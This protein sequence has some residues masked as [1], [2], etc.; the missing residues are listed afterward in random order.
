MADHPGHSENSLESLVTKAEPNILRKLDQKER[1]KLFGV[2]NQAVTRTVE[3]T[4]SE[5]RHHSGPLPPADELARINE[6]VPGGA[7]RILSM[8]EK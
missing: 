7:N 4:A 1:S 5:I 6:V 8:A 3:I 2:L